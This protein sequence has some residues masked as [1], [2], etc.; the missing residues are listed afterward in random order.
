MSQQSERAVKPEETEATLTPPG[1]LGISQLS[2]GQPLVEKTVIH[3]T[4]SY[5]SAIAGPK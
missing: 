5:S 2:E 1:T 3:Q 4:N